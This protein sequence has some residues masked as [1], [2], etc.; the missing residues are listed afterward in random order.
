MKIFFF[1]PLLIAGCAIHL[2]TTK[3]IIVTPDVVDAGLSP[4]LSEAERVDGGI[5]LQEAALL[6]DMQFRACESRVVIG[7]AKAADC[8][9]M[10][11]RWDDELARQL[12]APTA[13]LETVTLTL[14]EAG[15]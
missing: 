2:G 11:V 6:H 4:Y 13:R 3:N 15:R 12:D 14:S 10:L 1:L 7:E 8:D 5:S 9:D